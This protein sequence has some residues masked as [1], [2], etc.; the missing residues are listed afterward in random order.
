MVFL[1]GPAP[2]VGGSVIVVGCED[3]NP[4]TPHEYALHLPWWEGEH[5]VGKRQSM[6]PVFPRGREPSGLLFGKSVCVYI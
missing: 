5:Q 4:Q 2:P 3:Q 1:V 6:G